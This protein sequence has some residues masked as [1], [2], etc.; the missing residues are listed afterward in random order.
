MTIPLLLELPGPWAGC[1]RWS[2]GWA[3]SRARG[4]E[5]NTGRWRPSKGKGWEG[6][7]VRAGGR[8]PN[9]PRSEVRGRAGSCQRNKDSHKKYCQNMLYPLTHCSSMNFCFSPPPAPPPPHPSTSGPQWRHRKKQIT[10][11]SL[12]ARSIIRNRCPSRPGGRNSLRKHRHVAQ[13]SHSF[14]P[15][16]RFFSALPR[17]F[18]LLVTVLPAP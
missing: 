4:A 18:Q 8:S 16:N 1:M 12:Q 9:T 11:D 2:P 13:T 10:C 3:Q 17:A 5:G 6:L 15:R 14:P 7:R